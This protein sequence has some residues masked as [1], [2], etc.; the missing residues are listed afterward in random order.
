VTGISAPPDELAEFAAQEGSGLMR[1]AFLLT[2]DAHAAEDLVQTVLERLTKRGI[3]DLDDPA[4]YA[5][6]ALLNL[7]RTIGR[8]ASTYLRVVRGLPV[9][10]TAPTPDL[11]LRD[12]VRRALRTLNNRQ[13]AA[14]VLR[15][16]E[17]RPDEEIAEILGCERATVR[18]LVARALPK[19]RPYL[20]E[21]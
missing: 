17:D 2:G 11:E 1:F 20:E 21:S 7:H 15:Y 19:L 13:R 5:R 18:S 4:M 9:R 3:S 10:E 6:R 12:A 14:I 16:Y 8:R